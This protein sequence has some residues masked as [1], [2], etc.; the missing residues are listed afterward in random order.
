MSVKDQFPELSRHEGLTPGSG[1][2]A[3]SLPLAL[4]K[5]NLSNYGV[6]LYVEEGMTGSFH[7]FRFIILREGLLFMEC[8]SK[9]L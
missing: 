9:C 6:L 1:A 5:T 2:L 7:N 3:R 8:R 4:E